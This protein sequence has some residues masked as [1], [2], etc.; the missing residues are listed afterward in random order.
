MGLEDDEIR[1]QCLRRRGE[2]MKRNKVILKLDVADYE[3]EEIMHEV[4][5]YNFK[6][7]DKERYDDDK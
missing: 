5:N 4:R 2:G 6:I 7:L 1:N 3:L